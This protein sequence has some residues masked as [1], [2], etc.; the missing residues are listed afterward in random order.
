MR[1]CLA[2]WVR[3]SQ[4]PDP[5]LLEGDMTTIRNLMWHYVGLVRTGDRL[6]RAQRELRHL[7]HEIEEFYRTDSAQ[8]STGRAAQCSTSRANGDLGGLA[9]PKQLWHALSRGRSDA[10]QRGT[11]MS[12]EIYLDHSATTPTDPRVVEA[13]QPTGARLRQRLQFAWRGQGC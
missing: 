6:Q 13:M 4:L 12:E 5:A 10:G 1:A 8:R 2:G 11:A 9:Q 7:W 3:S